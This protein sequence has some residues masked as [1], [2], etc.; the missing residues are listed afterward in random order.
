M[1]NR[2]WTRDELIIAFNLYCKIQFSKINYKNELIIKLASYIERTPSSVAWKLVNFASLDPSLKKRGIRGASNVSKLDTQIFNEFYENWDE[3]LFESEQLL[4]RYENTTIE[5]KYEPILIDLTDKKGEVKLREVKTRVNQN[6]F[7]QLILSIYQKKC[8]ISGIDISAMLVAG[9]ILPWATNE[10]ERLNPENGICLSSIYDKAFEKG[11]LGI[12]E[13][14]R[15]LI[16]NELKKNVQKDYYEPFF[17]R[18]EGKT[19]NLPDRFLPNKEFL[20]SH[21]NSYFSSIRF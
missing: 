14:Y 8:A 1:I 7:Q 19:I 2:N 16:S 4:T 11:F 17:G 20:A 21:L 10:K 18:F 15:I 5:K 13:N 12:D 9:H 6:L 3:M